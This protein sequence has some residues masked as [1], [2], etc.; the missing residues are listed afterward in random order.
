MPSFSDMAEADLLTA[1]TRLYTGLGD[2]AEIAAAL[3]DYGYGKSAA[4]DGLALIAALRD[5][6]RAQASETAEK[7]T[8]SQASALAT[9]A[10]RA[11]LVRH[12]RLARRAH[13]RG[14]AGHSALALGGP[15]PTYETDLF[16][17]AR[18][19]YE[20]IRDS[21]E[22]AGSVRS[23]GPEAVAAALARLDAA[24]AAEDDQ[25]RE[26]GEAQRATALRQVAEAA[27][28][29]EAAEL[30][31]AARDALT[32]APQLVEVLGLTEPGT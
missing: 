4:A 12:R 7:L 27:L 29:T 19:F 11:P 8:A 13:P 14:T 16:V 15:L 21:P 9:A 31:E 20:L 18:R 23:L 2:N 3:K 28:R 26:A 22:F 30:A 10:V 5:A 1:T 32:D 25:T 17:A 6:M 24:E